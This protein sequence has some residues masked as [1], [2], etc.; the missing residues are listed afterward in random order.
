MT[1]KNKPGGE[2]ALNSQ[3]KQNDLASFTYRHVVGAGAANEER[4]SRATNHCTKL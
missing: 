3:L 1:L 4:A 2:Q